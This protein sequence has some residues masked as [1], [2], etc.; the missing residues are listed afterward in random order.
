MSQFTIEL[1]GHIV[2][3]PDLSYHDLLDREEQAKAKVQD[4]LEKASAEFIHFEALG[5]ILRFQCALPEQNDAVFHSICDDLAPFVTN[6]L[7][8]RLLLVDRDLN[9]VYFYTIV[10]GKWQEA[11]IGFP[12]PGYLAPKPEPVV[13]KAQTEHLEGTKQ[14][15]PKNKKSK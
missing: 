4:V 14:T 7:D 15:K 13:L 11:T 6:G 3:S 10:N 1:F 12:P 9:A 2:Y 5:D 8:A